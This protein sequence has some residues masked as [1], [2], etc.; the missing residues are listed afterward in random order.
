MNVSYE[1]FLN[2]ITK[3]RLKIESFKH[4]HLFET[5]IQS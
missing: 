3:L 1:D 2:K 4:F 5:N